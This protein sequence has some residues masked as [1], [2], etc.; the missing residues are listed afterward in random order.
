M[1][2][3]A[4]G[5]SGGDLL[6]HEACGALQ[7]PTLVCLTL[8]PRLYKELSVAPS[9]GAWVERFDAVLARAPGS[10]VRILQTNPQPPAWME[11]PA[12]SMWARTN[13]WMVEEA[14]AAAPSQSLVALWDGAIG[15]GPGGTAHMVQLARD[16]GIVEPVIVQPRLP[17]GPGRRFLSEAR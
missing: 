14:L 7:I 12:A 13:L 9:G 6:F 1:V 17:Q 15:E 5:A 3:L 16:A 8:P 11:T 10:A 2:G 4:G